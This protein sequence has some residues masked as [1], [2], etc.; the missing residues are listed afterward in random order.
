MGLI[1]RGILWR[2]AAGERGLY[3]VPM[4]KRVAGVMAVVAVASLAGCGPASNTTSSA[5]I[6]AAKSWASATCS[7]V[8]AW[9]VASK[10]AFNVQPT[11]TTAADARAYFT[12]ISGKA[13]IAAAG[14]EKAIKSDGTPSGSSGAT[15]EDRLIQDTQSILS[16]QQSIQTAA[17][18][19]PK[20]GSSTSSPTSGIISHI[21]TLSAS[22]GADTDS[23]VSDLLA[24]IPKVDSSAF[25]ALPACQTLI[26]TLAPPS[27]PSPT[28]APT[29]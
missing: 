1:A 4:H 23:F 21:G 14:L 8:Q 13:V 20:T 28:P 11:G 5:T 18:T 25:T 6:V 17:G 9:T 7:N 24:N 2:G 12:T 3:T 10:A 26:H 15:I 29:P 22:L 16:D 27:S 19:I